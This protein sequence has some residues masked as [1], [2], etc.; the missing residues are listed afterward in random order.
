MH[1]NSNSIQVTLPL[2]LATYN[3]FQVVNILHKSCHFSC[4]GHI[5][6]WLQKL[7]FDKIESK[8]M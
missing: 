1:V 3:I 4:Q 2:E 5:K 7:E 8:I 6:T